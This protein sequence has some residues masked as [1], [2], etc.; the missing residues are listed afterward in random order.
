M[1]ET[2]PPE[3]T[4]DEK[5]VKDPIGVEQLPIWTVEVGDKTDSSQMEANDYSLVKPSYQ[6]SG[7][8]CELWEGHGHYA[9]RNIDSREILD[10]YDSGL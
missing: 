2:L 7:Q 1:I 10:V 8:N 4:P 6:Y 5:K 9:V 3:V